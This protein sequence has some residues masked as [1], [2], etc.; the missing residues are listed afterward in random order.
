MV[1]LDYRG[2]G[3]G[4][5]KLLCDAAAVFLCSILV[6]PQF[7][8]GTLYVAAIL[9]AIAAGCLQ[10]SLAKKPA[11]IPEIAFAAVCLFFPQFILGIPLV[12]YG[13][14]ENERYISSAA[15]LFAAVVGFTNGAVPLSQLPAFIG[16]CVLAAILAL[17][18]RRLLRLESELLKTRDSDAELLIALKNK[19]RAILEKQDSEVNIATL[20]ERNRIAR[21][22]HDN[23][24]HLLSRSLLQMGALL[25]ITDKEQQP[26][27]YAAAESVKSTL[28]SAMN[29]IR[30]SVHGLRDDSL[31]LKRAVEE[32]VSEMRGNYKVHLETDF[33]ENMPAAVKLCFIAT[34]KE[35]MSNII[36]HSEADE[37]SVIIREHPALYQLC[38]SD[39]GKGGKTGNEGM[40]LANM[41]DRVDSLHGI[42]RIDAENGF[43]IF[44]SIRKEGLS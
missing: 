23:V 27:Q 43:K 38:I 15:C 37:V 18:T 35:A 22:I 3:G 9:A 28:N 29:S 2:K 26:V 41:R 1:K 40:G 10:Y 13:T 25:A 7:S 33:S 42:M 14:V 4:F 8:D 16:A 32:A 19:N 5:L 36:K 24:G 20:R 31:D 21:E 30:E 11:Y 39:N 44:I 34:V 6:L 17:R 12:L